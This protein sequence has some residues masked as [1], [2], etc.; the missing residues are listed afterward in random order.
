MLK[1]ELTQTVRTS[2]HN[3]GKMAS[4][5]EWEQVIRHAPSRKTARYQLMVNLVRR[6]QGRSSLT[7][8][9]GEPLSDASSNSCNMN[10]SSSSKEKGVDSAGGGSLPCICWLRA[11]AGS[12]RLHWL[13]AKCKH[14]HKHGSC[15]NF[16]QNVLMNCARLLVC[17]HEGMKLIQRK[18]S[19]ALD[20]S[21]KNC[22]N[23]KQNVQTCA[24]L[25]V[26]PQAGM[27]LDTADG[28]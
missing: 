9:L 3:I 19:G 13:S 10:A 14:G 8:K 28:R 26:C 15:S 7:A 18:E 17:P 4:T 25:L 11:S 2:I 5:M 21:P 24:R 6:V 1:R 27:G 16:K 23:F 22:V 20:A 12:G